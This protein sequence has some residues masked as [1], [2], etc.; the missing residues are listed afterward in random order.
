MFPHSR[1][2]N[3]SGSMHWMREHLI[4]NT[5]AN[6]LQKAWQAVD[7]KA[8]GP[9]S[10]FMVYIN[11][12]MWFWLLKERRYL[13]HFKCLLEVPIAIHIIIVQA[14]DRE[15]IILL[16]R[17]LYL[18][19]LEP[20][21]WLTCKSCMHPE[22]RE[23]YATRG[24]SRCKEQRGIQPCLPRSSQTHFHFHPRAS[25]DKHSGRV[26]RGVPLWGRRS[27]SAWDRGCVQS[28][29]HQMMMNCRWLHPRHASPRPNRDVTY[30]DC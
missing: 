10:A 1:A 23:M 21:W 12:K 27:S 3:G 14:W 30:R 29:H 2:E 19:W 20:L 28:I 15:R 18:S 16:C 13:W 24:E 9:F 22:G 25:L 17:F 7:S 26:M 5:L 11:G 6:T 4:C 8:A